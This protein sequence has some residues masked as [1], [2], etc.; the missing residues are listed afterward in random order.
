VSTLRRKAESIFEAAIVPGAEYDNAALVVDRSGG[1]RVLNSVEWSLS[2]I[3]SEFGA[4]SVYLI[5]RRS[6]QLK[7]EGWSATE[8]CVISDVPR[9]ANAATGFG[10][11]RSGENIADVAAIRRGVKGSAAAC[12]KLEILD[13]HRY[14]TGL[15]SDK[16]AMDD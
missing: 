1:I 13:L 15:L 12:P 9:P 4:S 16:Q 6:G 3:V 14:G 8:R 11:P 10:R 5:N 2:G 7:V